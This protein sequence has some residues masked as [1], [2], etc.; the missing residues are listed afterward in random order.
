M[1]TRTGILKNSPLTMVFASVRFT[2]WPVLGKRIDEIQNDLRDVLPLMHRIE[3][4]APEGM[5]TAMFSSEAWMLI[6]LDKSYGVQ[7]TKDQL[8]IFCPKYHHYD[9]FE[10]KIDRVLSTLLTHMKFMNVLNMGVRFID[11]VKPKQG[12]KSSHYISEKFLAPSIENYNTLGGQFFN[13]YSCDNHRIRVNVLNMPG[14]LPVPQDAIPVLAIFNGIEAPLKLEQLKPEE[15]LVDMDAVTMFPSAEKL[16]K[17]TIIF[18]LRKLHTV[19]NNFFRH[20]EMFSDH[21]FKV[22]KGES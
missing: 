20:T 15:L 16:A 22:W 14:A 5:P 7:I 6:S 4:E 11:H 17:E 19:A 1:T 13:E 12:E 18:E 21:A 8:L 9:D 10:A 2:P 3:V